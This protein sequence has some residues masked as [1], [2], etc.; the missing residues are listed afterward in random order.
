MSPSSNSGKKYIF[1]FMDETGILNST[2][3]E[4]VFA[5]GLLKL[6]HPKDVH[7][8]IISLKDRRQFHNEFKFTN[9]TSK[10]QRLYCE[11]IDIFFKN[12]ECSF[13]C[14]VFDKTKI[15]LNKFFNGNYINAYNSYCAKL[16]ADSL[17]KGE[18][19]AIIADDISRPKSDNFEKK[20]KTKIKKKINRNALFGI[21]RV[22]SHAIS[23]LQ[24]VDV[25]LGLVGY[26]YKLKYN[27]ESPSK[28]KLHMLKH[29][30]EKLKINLLSENFKNKK[31]G[32]YFEVNEF[33]GFIK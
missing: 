5:I 12:K 6:H 9:I 25:L 4:R 22:E 15:D 13:S 16:I 18:Y 28:V 23:E 10:N 14:I 19:I 31:T 20:I 8:E 11:L 26:S 33:N 32:G 21:V 3:T 7:R 17:D 24:L 1:G 2:T 30:Q 27:K 29:L